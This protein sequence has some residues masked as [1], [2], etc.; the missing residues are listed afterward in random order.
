MSISSYKDLKVWQSSMDLA[1]QVYVF[2]R[3][4][5]YEVYGLSSQIQRAAVSILQISL[6]E[7]QE[8]QLRNFCSLS[9]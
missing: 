5:K 6:K 8:I 4:P 2:T 7:A 3:I 9:Q 1:K